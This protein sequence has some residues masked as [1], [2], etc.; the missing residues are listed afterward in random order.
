MRTRNGL[1]LSFTA[2][3]GGVLSEPSGTL[4]MT[5]EPPNYLGSQECV[6]TLT[7]DTGFGVGIIFSQLNVSVNTTT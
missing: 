3:C 1:F 6:W 4:A 7:V 5:E 2:K